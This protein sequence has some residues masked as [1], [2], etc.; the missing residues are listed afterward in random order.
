MNSGD[1]KPEGIATPVERKRPGRRPGSTLPKKKKEQASSEARRVA[2]VVLEVLGGVLTPPE[3]AAAL[4]ISPP[5]YY[6]VEMRALE[7][8][9]TACEP[10]PRGYS[11]N[12]EKELASLNARCAK[13]ERENA[14]YQALVRAAQRTVGLS[15]AHKTDAVRGGKKVR[16]RKP[17][18]RALALA[19]RLKEETPLAPQDNEATGSLGP[20]GSG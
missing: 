1:Q 7:G 11:Q 12:A 15:A 9:L 18:V 2:Q 4:G 14:R 5:R 10:R 16:A 17:V 13:L 20:V 3:A 19:A 8:M 6:M